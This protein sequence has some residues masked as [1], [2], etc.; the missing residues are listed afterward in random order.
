MNDIKKDFK[1]VF[2]STFITLISS[3]LVGFF[4]P[5]VLGV[6]EFGYYKLF[7]LYSSYIGLLHFGYIDGVFINY[8]G[9]S[10]KELDKEKFRTFTLFFISF[11]S[12]IGLIIVLI[13]LVF[14]DDVYKII[15]II[16]GINVIVLNLSKY[17]Q[18]IAQSVMRFK[19]ISISQTIVSICRIFIVIIVLYISNNN[20]FD[21][22]AESYLLIMLIL[23]FFLLIWF[24]MKYKN[25]LIGIRTKFFDT[26]KDIIYLFKIGFILNISFQITQLIFSLDRQFISVFYGNEIFSIYSFAYNIV[27]III[28]LINGVSIILLPR[29][30]RLSDSQIIQNYEKNNSL[31]LI[32]SYLSLIG[33]IPL[34]MIIEEFLPD[35]SESIVYLLIL[36][37]GLPIITVL[38]SIT[39]TYFKALNMH[40]KYLKVSLF[41]FLIA[42]LFN[43]ITYYVFKLPVYLSVASVFTLFLWYYINNLV[44]VK[45]FAIKFKKNTVY[46]FLM[47]LSFYTIYFYS[48]DFILATVLYFVFFTILTFILQK[49]MIL[50]LKKL[51]IKNNYRS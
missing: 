31:V 10:F 15:F 34:S 25:I 13:S 24:I 41:V 42:I 16:L 17:Y 21:I 23:D 27:F 35:Y 9:K 39:F 2:F 28:A 11:Q 45:K 37:S 47:S 29:L 19:Q 18:Y 30:K 3:I 4:I 51:I 12:I 36:F 33:F 8:A 43:F 50:N 46:I 22:K 38:S 44:L 14:F 26:Y 49:K 1:F 32:L 40:K 5:A 7:A 6:N 20:L 48:N